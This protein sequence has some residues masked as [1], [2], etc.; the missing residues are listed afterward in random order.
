[1]QTAQVKQVKVEADKATEL[2]LELS[3]DAK[4]MLPAKPD[5]KKQKKPVIH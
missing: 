3:F 2:N 1:M 4:T 5:G